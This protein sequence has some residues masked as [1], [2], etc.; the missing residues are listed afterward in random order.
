MDGIWIDH[1]GKPFPRH[2][3]LRDMVYVRF[4]DGTES[5][6]AEHVSYF[7]GYGNNWK[8]GAP[9]DPENEIVAYKVVR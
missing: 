8:W 9:A 4:R 2:A 5:R 7:C 3:T 1:D 6:Y